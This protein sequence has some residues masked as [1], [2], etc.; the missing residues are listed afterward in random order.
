VERSEAADTP[1]RS[2]A[3]RPAVPGDLLARP[4]LVARLEAGV[5]MAGT[6]VVAP[7]GFG[8]STL[9]SA[10]AEGTDHP[11]A[12][13][14]L[15]EDCGHLEPFVRHLV[16][17]IRVALPGACEATE[18]LLREG[19]P[20]VAAELSES[21]ILDLQSIAGS[22][23]VVLDDYSTV[24]GAD[25]HDL[26]HRILSAPTRS[27]HI[28]IVASHD[29]PIYVQHLAVSGRLQVMRLA[30]LSFSR[31]EAAAFLE[32]QTGE[33]LEDEQLAL[34]MR[35]LGGWPA[36]LK[37]LS[38]S[39]NSSAAREALLEHLPV[40]VREARSYLCGELLDG[41]P[42]EIRR[43][44]LEASVVGEFN[45]SLCAAISEQRGTGLTAR[46]FMEQEK[47]LVV[48][49]A[50]RSG[51]FRLHGLVR[52]TLEQRL[53]EVM[54][55]DAVRSLHD[56]AAEWFAEQGDLSGAVRHALLGRDPNSAARI[57]ARHRIRFLNE[58]RYGELFQIA[59]Q[60]PQEIRD[61]SLDM[62]LLQVW[63]A[64]YEYFEQAVS[65][66]E[67]LVAQHRGPQSDTDAV[68]GELHLMR[69]G[70]L[71]ARSLELSDD[72]STLIDHGRR[73]LALLPGHF[74]T[75]RAMSTHFLAQTQQYAG[76][77]TGAIATLDAGVEEH[78]MTRGHP[79][80]LIHYARAYL[81]LADADYQGARDAA[82]LCL[83]SEPASSADAPSST[84]RLCQSILGLVHYEWNDLDRA[85]EI[86]SAPASGQLPDD[87]LHLAHVRVAQG[88]MPEASALVAEYLKQHGQTTHTPNMTFARAHEAL[89]QLRLGHTDAAVGWAV[90]ASTSGF[91]KLLTSITCTRIRAEILIVA[92]SEGHRALASELIA[93]LRGMAAKAHQRRWQIHTLV[94]EVLLHA[95]A[96]DDERAFAALSNV[97]ELSAP[98]GFIR[99]YL[100]L[101]PAMS[102]LLA[103]APVPTHQRDYVDQIREAFLREP[104][105]AVARAQSVLPD[106]L[107]ER[108]LDV[109]K[110]LGERLSNKEIAARLFVSPDTVKTHVSRIYRKLHVNRRRD[111]V[112][113]AIAS[114][115]LADA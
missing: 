43:Y 108:E 90:G 81:H 35:G 16:E 18:G 104:S 72:L 41:R 4:H 85:A 73:A 98:G 64:P 2:P 71:A 115:L 111:A 66:V 5:S 83:A 56:R 84:A 92:G 21:L 95:S 102:A 44:L 77:M 87:L 12:W 110:L 100:D 94:L 52:E 37:L 114:G 60:I 58:G 79:L 51:W 46:E 63:T 57:L 70:M 19:P 30:D 68:H 40:G 25:V 39:L 33:P 109:L 55:G 27:V 7:A 22:A 62:C 11:V 34:V 50:D 36:G 75:P 91:G 54:D 67:A 65:R 105:S 88:R 24:Q 107:T 23:V 69:L 38:L 48:P 13:L 53:T 113:K 93:E 17:A 80:T 86:F 42:A 106:P 76:D 26:L 74:R 78:T 29:P 32:R 101:G 8:K 20:I 3:R 97:L 6:L 31:P 14:N 103:R 49:V 89:L 59:S 82:E 15:S 1:S 28:V 99:V 61:S 10:W 96:G 9:A 112:E 47:T 45:V